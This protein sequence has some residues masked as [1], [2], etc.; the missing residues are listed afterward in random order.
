M[1]N[2]LWKLGRVSLFSGVVLL[3][4]T[5]GNAPAS[6]AKFGFNEE[7]ITGLAY[8]QGFV[9]PTCAVNVPPIPF[10][11]IMKILDQLASANLIAVREILP[12]ALL[13]DE[14]SSGWI[15]QLLKQYM[16]RHMTVVLSLGLPMSSSLSVTGN[17]T[18]IIPTDAPG[19]AL[20][21]T[22]S[23]RIADLL[24][25][26]LAAAVQQGV[27]PAALAAWMRD[28]LTIDP[29]NEFDSL[30]GW[31]ST[32][33]NKV[34]RTFTAGTPER[35][36]ILAD[37]IRDDMQ[38]N[39]LNGNVSAPSIVNV[40][41]RKLAPYGNYIAARFNFGSFMAWLSEYYRINGRGYPNIHLYYGARNVFQ[42][43]PDA[44]FILG[45]SFEGLETGLRDV[46]SVVPA[47]YKNA[48]LVTEA[49][50]GQSS[51]TCTPKRGGISSD[52]R[53][54]IYN[55][56]VR[57]PVLRS[58]KVFLFW[59]VLRLEQNAFLERVVALAHVTHAWLPNLPNQQLREWMKMNNLACEAAFGVME[60]TPDGNVVKLPIFST[61]VNGSAR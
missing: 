49:G 21:Q 57:S 39:H 28:N 56:I 60:V 5:T 54:N 48:V 7:F 53:A 26:R 3:S 32:C 30:G 61:I 52:L 59:R 46:K 35:G 47:Q 34:D 29:W 55:Q 45:N 24:T 13:E 23:H 44:D 33:V 31:C 40:Y 36:K 50:F 14:R 51:E 1:R 6:A 16:D 8:S 25:K 19:N 22:Q 38:T 18:F 41:K 2:F 27:Q 11:T 20:W 10:T 4:C 58:A 37:A 9:C 17:G 15:A 42:S 43:P 12:I